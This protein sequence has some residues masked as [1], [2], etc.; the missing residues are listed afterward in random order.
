MILNAVHFRTNEQ[1]KLKD[2]QARSDEVRTRHA[3]MFWT[4]E[5]TCKLKDLHSAL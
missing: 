2:G 4:Q 5:E 3:Y 1:R